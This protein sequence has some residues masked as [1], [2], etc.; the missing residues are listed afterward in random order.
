MPHRDLGRGAGLDAHAFAIGRPDRALV[1][2]Y[3]RPPAWSSGAYRGTP[4]RPTG[5]ICAATPTSWPR[6]GSTEPG[7]GHPALIS[8]YAM[9]LREG[10]PGTDGERLGASGRWARPAWPGPWWPSAA[11]TGS[12]STEGVTPT[13]RPHAVTPPRP[14]RRL[15]KALSLDQVQA[16][17]DVPATDTELGLRDAALL[18][19]LY[20]TGARISEAVGLD[21]DDDRPGVRSRRPQ[22]GRSTPGLRLLGKGSKERV[23]PLGSLRPARPWTRTWSG[24]VRPW[25]RAAAAPRPCSS[26]PAAAGCPGRAPG[27]CCRT[28]AERAGITADVSPHTLRHSLRHPPAGRRRRRTGGPGTARPRLGDHDPDLHPGHRGPPTG[29]LP[30]R[31]SPRVLG[32]GGC[33]YGRHGVRRGCRGRAFRGRRPASQVAA[34]CERTRTYGWT[35]IRSS[36]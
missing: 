15:P 4:W 9:R 14:P 23:V 30:D 6:A 21:V 13:I 7:R 3:P 29:G 24:P 26:T 18:E 36:R 27:R 32:C 2:S 10:E 22:A 16:M 5:A 35:A 19:L 12:P 31:A 33:E 28:A 17:L 11:C 8:E 34:S 20:G 25:P 1:E